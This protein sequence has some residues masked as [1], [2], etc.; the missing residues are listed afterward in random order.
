MAIF[1]PFPT[2]NR[3]DLSKCGSDRAAPLRSRD[4]YCI[5][6]ITCKALLTSACLLAHLLI[7]LSF[8]LAVCSQLYWSSGCS[9]G[10]R[11]SLKVLVLTFWEDPPTPYP[12]LLT[13]MSHKLPLLVS[14][15]SGLGLGLDTEDTHVGEM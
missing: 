3:R 11:S 2:K 1:D 6:I 9:L 7:G 4:E 14:S 15:A 5:V 10:L 8:S 13:P 12:E